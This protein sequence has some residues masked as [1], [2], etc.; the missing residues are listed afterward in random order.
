MA[1]LGFWG[2]FFV[3]RRLSKWKKLSPTKI[4]KK[5]AEWEDILAQKSFYI[6]RTYKATDLYI[7]LFWYIK[8]SKEVKHV[9]YIYERCSWTR[10]KE[11]LEEAEGKKL[12]RIIKE[13]L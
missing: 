1:D 4:M 12:P 10:A 11:V 9:D 5:D 13:V 6:H 3:K 2:R 8:P 7:D